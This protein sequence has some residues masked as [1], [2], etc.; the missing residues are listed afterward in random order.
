MKTPNLFTYATSELSQDAFI[1]W[2][3][4]WG[5]SELSIVDR[6]L[7]LCA[8]KFL[9]I[10]FTKHSLSVPKK[11]ETLVVSKQDNGIDVLCVINNEYAIIIEDKTWT[12]EH[13]DQLKRYYDDVCSRGVDKDKIIAIYYKSEDQSNYESINKH[14]YYQVIRSEM[15]E[16]LECYKGNNSILLDYL[17]HLVNKENAVMGFLHTPIVNWDYY[18]WVGF[19]KSLQKTLSG[20]W[21]YVANPSGGFL[22][23]WWHFDGGDDCDRYI[24]LEEEKLC[25]KISVD[26]SEDKRK[27]RK[28]WHALIMQ[29]ARE[30]SVSLNVCK[31]TRFGSGTYMTVCIADKDYR[32]TN[33]DGVLDLNETLKVLKDA[34]LIL[35]R[36]I[37]I[38]GTPA[39]V[40]TVLTQ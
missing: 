15:I 40:Q 14:G 27:V 36:A 22:G 21:D 5:D 12:N 38:A 17:V 11:I 16:I 32:I 1:C 4:S 6:E 29:V 33:I 7:H 9:S 23:F 34:E 3:L 13:S 30:M 10:M 31:P 39:I 2:L 28:K 20:N 18:C 8:R 37:D 19:Y 25:F 35:T 24:Q 26:D